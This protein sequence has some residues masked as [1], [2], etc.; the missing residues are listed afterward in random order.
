VRLYGFP[1]LQR[2]PISALL[3]QALIA[4]TLEL[5]NEFERQML[6]AG[7]HGIGLSLVVW[8]NL[9]RFLPPDGISVGE[10]G[11]QA[12]GTLERTLH[13]LGCLERWR[14]LE[15]DA[16]I[17]TAASKPLHAHRRT[18]RLVRDGHGS[19]R[20]VRRDWI[21]KPTDKGRRACAIWPPLF[22]LIED[23]WSRRFGSDDIQELRT[24]LETI[25]GGIDVALPDAVPHA[26]PQDELETFQPRTQMIT[27]RLPLATL[28]SKAVF[29]CA[30]QFNRES[31]APLGLAANV[32]RCVT[33]DGVRVG[34][35]ASL[36]GGS[37]E[38]SALG[39][40][41]TPYVV[42]EA[43]RNGRG[44]IVPLSPYGLLVQRTYPRLL[45]RI[46]RRWEEQ[47]GEQ[48][49]ADLHASL[50]ALFRREPNGSTRIAQGLI[51]PPGVRRSGVEP[52]WP[53]VLG[54]AP[55]ER[56]RTREMA[57]QTR[58]FIDDPAGTLPHYPLWDMNRGFG[59]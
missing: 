32:L 15:F 23:R 3:S 28:L 42:V 45:A 1:I 40:R 54:L 53:S 58:A 5:D 52:R 59:P 2:L 20:G 27:G 41:L 14:F 17:R 10:L 50:G 16:S 25:A 47:H 22:E 55:A 57:Q 7:F 21:V 48:V 37:P 34:D 8:S 56:K 43:S 35:L 29:A 26:S 24:L 33:E 13:L 6:D 39:W 38:T 9:L 49:V 31:A 36:T 44:K 12:Y 11:A 46:E 18:G 30:V 4:F 19:G 51:P